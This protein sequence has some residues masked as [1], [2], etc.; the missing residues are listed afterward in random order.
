M[1]ARLEATVMRPARVNVNTIAVAYR[2]EHQ[3]DDE[4]RLASSSVNGHQKQN[5]DEGEEDLEVHRSHGREQERAG[6][7]DLS[8]E[9]KDGWPEVAERLHHGRDAGVLEDGERGRP[10]RPWP[11]QRQ[12]SL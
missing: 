5:G 10:A 4:G 1:M 12:R 6:R 9:E 8:A 2:H 3:H 7:P 11:P